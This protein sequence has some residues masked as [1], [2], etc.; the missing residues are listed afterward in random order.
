MTPAPDFRT[1][2]VA[3]D[4]VNST[5]AFFP[6]GLCPF[7]TKQVRATNTARNAAL[8]REAICRAAVVDAAL[9]ISHSGWMRVCTDTDNSAVFNGLLGN[10]CDAV[11]ALRALQGED[12]PPEA[13]TD[14]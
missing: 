9:A 6:N 7:H 1:T 3:P 13:M 4:C 2:C 8:A 5:T 11:A 14:A 12:A 10:V